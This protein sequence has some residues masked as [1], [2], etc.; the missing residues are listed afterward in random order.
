MSLAICITIAVLSNG[1]V[2]IKKKQTERDR[3]MV[4]LCSTSFAVNIG[5]VSYWDNF[6]NLK[7][8]LN[9]MIFIIHDDEKFSGHAA[10]TPAVPSWR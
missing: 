3:L 8:R 9:L 5:S 2:K 1:Y 10:L 6:A 7:I 4:L